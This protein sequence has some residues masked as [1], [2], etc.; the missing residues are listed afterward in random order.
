[1][2]IKKIKIFEEIKDVNNDNIDVGVVNEMGY[3]YIVTVG[4]PQDLLEEMKQEKTDFIKP[5]SPMIIVK[6]LTEEIIAEAI[7]AYAAEN[8]G[9]W[10]KLRHFD[11]ELDVSIFDKLEAKDRKDWEGFEEN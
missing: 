5:Y 9:F 10:L 1:M 8:N 7:E 3:T 2:K 11:T 6:S 4:T